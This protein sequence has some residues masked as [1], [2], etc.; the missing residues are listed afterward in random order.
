MP[1]SH[2]IIA[3][4][5]AQT[6]RIGRSRRENVPV[7]YLTGTSDAEAYT[8]RIVDK[9]EQDLT[10]LEIENFQ[11][12]VGIAR[13]VDPSTVVPSHTQAYEVVYS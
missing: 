3:S 2:S 10:M 5:Q 7:V 6:V 13:G 4:K 1:K 12:K 8:I 9:L 11:N